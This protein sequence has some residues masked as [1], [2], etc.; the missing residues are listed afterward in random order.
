[1]RISTYT[2]V[3]CTRI[4]IR[5]ETYI[6]RPEKPTTLCKQHGEHIRPR[7]FIMYM[8]ASSA[9]LL[10]MKK[11]NPKQT[12][13]EAQ[14]QGHV[15]AAVQCFAQWLRC[16]FSHIFFRDFFWLCSN[17]VHV[18]LLVMLNCA[19][20]LSR[21]FES[22]VT[23]FLSVTFI[24]CASLSWHFSL[25]RTRRVYSLC[26]FLF[27]FYYYYK[28]MMS[29]CTRALTFQELVPGKYATGLSTKGGFMNFDDKVKSLGT[30]LIPN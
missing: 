11:K 5:I 20:W 28:N 9:C 22:T 14:H 24:L 15:A 13:G 27:T 19:Q 21:K 8:K 3:S 2:S 25:V 26:I 6:K 12:S 4:Y 30:R 10:T 29:K 1:M 16:F 23:F 17:K 7:L 18:I